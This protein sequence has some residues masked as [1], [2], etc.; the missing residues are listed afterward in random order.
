M[1][2]YLYSPSTDQIA[3]AH[4]LYYQFE[5]QNIGSLDG[6]SIS[7]SDGE[8]VGYALEFGSEESLPMVNCRAIESALIDGRL[9]DLDKE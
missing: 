6:Y 2:R 1:I 8:P 9:I 3:M 5:E 7:L 4:A